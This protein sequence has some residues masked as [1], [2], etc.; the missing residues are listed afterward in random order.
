MEI[1]VFLF[2]LLFNNFKVVVQVN[3]HFRLHLLKSLI[4]ILFPVLRDAFIHSLRKKMVAY[5]I[6]I[7]KNNPYESFFSF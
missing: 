5:S 6:S 3:L 1:N 2:F 4:L 7:I